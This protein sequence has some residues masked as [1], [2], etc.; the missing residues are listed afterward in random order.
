MSKT[1]SKAPDECSDRVAHLLKLFHSPLFEAKVKVDVLS[2]ATDGE[3]P[4][5]SHQ[6]YAALAVVRVTNIK[7]RTKG[8][9][10][11]EIVIDE[12]RYSQLADAEKDALIDHELYHLEVIIDKKTLR[13]KLDCR[14]RPR[15]RTRKHDHQFG[16]FREI[17]DR[18]GA[19]AIEV[20][21]ATKLF[22]SEA[23]T[24]FAFVGEEARQ[25]LDAKK[26]AIDSA[27]RRFV[28]SSQAMI[29]KGDLTSVSISAGGKTAKI[30]ADG[31]ESTEQ[32][33]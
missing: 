5:L 23:Q 1:Y 16:W 20:K 9:G 11:A 25:I 3:G 30:T 15:L 8:L 6:G 32:A 28:E 10:D 27:A 14:G 12:E 17:A 26:P 4:A 2:V 29:R 24:Y 7:E 21:Q 33:P 22:L 13:P 18:H 31:V 19:A